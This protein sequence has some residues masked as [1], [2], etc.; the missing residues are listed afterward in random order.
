MQCSDTTEMQVAWTCLLPLFGLM[1]AVDLSESFRELVATFAAG[2]AGVPVKR[3]DE[4]SGDAGMSV[5]LA[6]VDHSI[7]TIVTESEEDGAGSLL[8][9]Y[10][11]MATHQTL[12]SALDEDDDGVITRRELLTM[13]SVKLMFSEAQAEEMLQVVLAD[14][15]EDAD[16]P[17]RPIELKQFEDWLKGQDD[18]L[19]K[20]YF[21][22]HAKLYYG[23]MGM[24]R[25]QRGLAGMLLQD[26]PSLFLALLAM[27]MSTNLMNQRASTI[28]S[29]ILS[30]IIT[31]VSIG[32]GVQ[33]FLWYGTRKSNLRALKR[34]EA[35]LRDYQTMSSPLQKLVVMARRRKYTKPK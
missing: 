8:P 30:L 17:D 31:G 9:P 20:E 24:R 21:K 32:R 2:L 3:M 14:L 22:V 28:Y 23:K 5:E 16:D 27:Q 33:Q 35:L 4:L 1:S 13:F 10:V 18:L 19:D 12:T 25:L 6:A 29:I 34:E 7:L 15:N 26:I 11:K